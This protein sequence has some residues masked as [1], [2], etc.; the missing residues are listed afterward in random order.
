MDF[1]PYATWLGIPADRRPPTFYDLLGVALDEPDPAA[2]EQAALRRMSKVR[3]HQIGPH[4]DLSQEILSELA[5]ARLIL[6]D[7]DRRTDYDATLRARDESRPARFAYLENAEKSDARRRRRPDENVADGLGSLVVVDPE[8]DGRRIVQPN[9]TKARAPRRSG[10]IIGTALAAN[11]AIIG[12]VLFYFF[13]RPSL[14]QETPTVVQNGR[15]SPKPAAPRPP[16]LLARANREQ[17]RPRAG[18][19]TGTRPGPRPRPQA[20]QPEPM[21]GMASSNGEVVARR[22]DPAEDDKQEVFATRYSPEE[23]LK[24]YGLKLEGS[25]YVLEGEA[26]VREKATEMRRLQ[27]EWRMAL[28]Q[29]EATASPE[30][31]QQTINYLV[32][33]IDKCHIQMRNAD[34]QMR[35]IPRYWYGSFGNPAAAERFFTLRDARDQ[36]QAYVDIANTYLKRLRREPFDPGARARADAAVKESWESYDQARDEFWKVVEATDQKYKELAKDQEISKALDAMRKK[37]RAERQLGPSHALERT[38]RA[39]AKAKKDAAKAEK[40][41][42]RRRPS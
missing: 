4:S 32:D 33:E 14:R 1:D 11:A 35:R 15:V 26:D 42:G 19:G 10:L 37:T 2:I 6:M 12:A 41:K 39:V 22:E 23:V 31:R 5:R 21:D 38:A 24:K 27:N 25:T 40:A 9:T 8:G 13:G 29:Q 30:A 18:Q 20:K 34:E 3:Q 36:M 28:K 17:P 7:P 16:A